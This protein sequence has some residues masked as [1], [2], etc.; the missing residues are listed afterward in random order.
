MDLFRYN[1]TRLLA[2]CGFDLQKKTDSVVTSIFELRAFSNNFERILCK[3]EKKLNK[4]FTNGARKSAS[5]GGV[6]SACSFGTYFHRL[7]GDPL[8]F[9]IEHIDGWVGESTR[10]ICSDVRSGG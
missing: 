5:R 7:D 4:N 9:V 8:L 10:E 6:V 2:R 1:V 3:S